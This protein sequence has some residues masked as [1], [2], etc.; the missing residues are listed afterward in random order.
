MIK[1]CLC[2][3]WISNLFIRQNFPL[4]AIWMKP[5]RVNHNKWLG[6][7]EGNRRLG[8]VC[9]IWGTE[10][11]FGECHQL[12]TS[13]STWLWG[14][15]M[16][17]E[18]EMNQC[19]VLTCAQWRYCCTQIEAN[20]SIRSTTSFTHRMSTAY[21][22]LERQVGPINYFTPHHT[23]NLAYQYQGYY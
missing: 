4:S 9:R 14:L 21:P 10:R 6:A 3:H 15:Q 5:F 23:I 12:A 20:K 16:T 8:K 7:W 18:T 13:M 22:A 1:V 11:P 19:A 17:S 2:Q